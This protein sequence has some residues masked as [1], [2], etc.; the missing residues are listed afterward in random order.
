DADRVAL[1]AREPGDERLAVERL[2]LVEP[3][4]VDDAS[5]ELTGVGL[6]FVVLWNQSVELGRIGRGRLRFGELPGRLGLAT[7]EVAN[8]LTGERER[9]LVRGGVVVGYA[10]LPCVH[11]G[12]AELLGADVLPRRRLHERWA[13][14]EDRPRAADDDRLVRHRGDI[15][16]AC[17]AGSHHDG[18][19]RNSPSRHLRL[20]EED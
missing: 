13:P 9:V 6:V 10:G 16:A 20:V 17:R 2:E 3:G 1:V 8:D 19:L 14:D 7:L 11:V 15:G 12:A 18:D 5:D 4:A